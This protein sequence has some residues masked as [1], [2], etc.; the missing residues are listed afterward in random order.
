MKPAKFEYVKP[1]SLAAALTL[2][3]D[4][5]EDAAVLG[6]G[7]SLVP[8]L[9]LRV[10]SPRVVIDINAIPE[11]D[12]IRVEGSALQIGARSRHNDVLR[13]ELVARH[14]PLLP[15]ALKNVAH[16]AIRNR[17]TLGGSLALADPA[18]EMPACMVCLDAEIVVQS[19]SGLRSVPAADFFQGI[20][21]TALEPDELITSI[22]I[23]LLDSSWRFAFHEIARR[24]GD[25]ALAGL[26]FGIQ[27]GGQSVQGC[28]AVFL[29]VEAFPR[30]LIEVEQA[31]IGMDLCDRRG[32]ENAIQFLPSN[33]EC[34]EGGEYPTEY[35]LYLAQ[36]LLSRCA[37]EA[38]G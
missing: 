18:A 14:A 8:M 34:L 2:L 12:E 6:G 32:L 36:Q 9:N 13:S 21:D 1:A 25:F 23:P 17:G 27:S 30:R 20:Y 7:Q 10:A 19:V 4:Y 24:H 37:A 35:R 33:L 15:L 3:R 11:L 5:R 28:R 38:L 26:A 29:G 16:E 22:R 31:F